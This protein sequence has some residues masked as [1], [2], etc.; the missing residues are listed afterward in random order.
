[1][2]SIRIVVVVILSASHPTAAVQFIAPD[3]VRFNDFSK[4]R[5]CRIGWALI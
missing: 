1:M 2:Q 5:D 4:G 3:A